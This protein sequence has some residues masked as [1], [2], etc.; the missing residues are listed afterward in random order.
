MLSILFSVQI[1]TSWPVGSPLSELFV[2]S[3]FLKNIFGAHA[4]ILA[5]TEILDSWKLFPAPKHEMDRAAENLALRGDGHAWKCPC[6][7]HS[8]N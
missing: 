2:L 5:T 1:I 6:S 7:W 8:K 3:G 4:C